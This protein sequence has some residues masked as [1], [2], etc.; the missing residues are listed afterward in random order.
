MQIR[1]ENVT[2]KWLAG[3]LEYAMRCPN[4][5]EAVAKEVEVGKKIRLIIYW[6]NRFSFW[7]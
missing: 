2:K 4:D 5:P 6:K 1:G 7:E 3:H